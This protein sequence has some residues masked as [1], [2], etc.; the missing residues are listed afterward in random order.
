MMHK[1]YTFTLGES[2]KEFAQKELGETDE[3]RE[4]AIVELRQWLCEN[5]RINAKSDD[6]SILYFLRGCKFDVE[7][8]KQKL[9]NFYVMK[10]ERPEWFTNRDPLLPEIQDLVKLGVFVPLRKYQDNR[11]V[12]IIRAAA[13]NPKIHLQDDVFKTGKMMLDIAALEHENAS[14]Y[15]VTAIFD[16]KGVSLA[17]AR[18]LPP[19]VVKKAVYA[20]QNYHCRP[21]QLEFVNAPVYV[22]VMLRIFKRFMS[23][24]LKSRINVHFR[25]LGSL[26]DKVAKDILPMEYGGSD[27][28]IRDS[29]EYW[30][31]KLVSYKGWFEED[32]KY[33]A[34]LV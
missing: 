14:V 19:S 6:V 8:T 20:W 34:E 17:H 3:R 10:T 12:V 33:K 25:G 30:N 22:N 28:S 21:K 24:K 18:Q 7:R 26:H 2:A 15:G 1:P 9:R 31:E 32:E 13:H 29:I 16:L 5:P 4:Q 11:L 23:E 27:G